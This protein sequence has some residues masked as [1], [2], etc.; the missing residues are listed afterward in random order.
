MSDDAAEVPEPTSGDVSGDLVDAVAYTLAAR[1]HRVHWAHPGLT[2]STIR[3]VLRDQYPE[4]QT[5]DVQQ[6]LKVLHAVEKTGTSGEDT[7]VAFWS[8]R[9]PQSVPIGKCSHCGDD[10]VEVLTWRQ[11]GAKQT[12]IC[13]ECA[14]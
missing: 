13:L 9:Q 6:A 4:L 5:S 1:K 7:G 3:R 14:G 12:S 11:P 10:N 2:V 8:L